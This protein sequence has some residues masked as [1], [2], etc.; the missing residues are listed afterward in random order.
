MK[1]AEAEKLADRK[2]FIEKRT[3]AKKVV[4]EAKGVTAAREVQER[5]VAEVW[6]AVMEGVP[7]PG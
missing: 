5:Q 7:W 4:E 6:D 3:H 2:A 1:V